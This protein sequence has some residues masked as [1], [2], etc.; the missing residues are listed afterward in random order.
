MAFLLAL[1]LLATSA[2]AAVCGDRVRQGHE[3]CD[4]TDTGG[5][6][7]ENLCFDGGLLRCAP[8]CTFDTSACTRCGNHRREPGEACDGTDLGGWTCPEGGTAACYPDCTAVDERGCFRCGNGTR[9]GTEE[10][11]QADLGGAAC[12][13]PGETGGP[14]ACTAACRIDRTGCWRCGNG[15]V[16]PGEE[17]DDGNPDLHD[18]C[19]PACT[20]ECGDGLLEPGEECDDGNRADGD[21]CSAL[22]ALESVYGGCILQWGAAGLAPDGTLACGDGAACDRG[23]VAGE[24]T[25]ALSYCVNVGLV[26]PASCRPTDVAAVALAPATTLAPA[27]R[28]AFLDAMTVTLASGGAA[29]NRTGERLVATPPLALRHVC[30]ALAVTVPAGAARILAAD[31]ADSAG[32]TDADRLTLTC[33]P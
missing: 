14:L 31:A 21:G 8:D 1:L 3:Q 12:D 7:C 11:D 32:T 16:D 9:E 18:G 13:A 25:V 27:D 23:S 22:C 10:C 6:L 2:H 17:C 19:T 4:G 28:A 33:A 29:V 5:L 24:C 26:A 20:T 15:R 30:G